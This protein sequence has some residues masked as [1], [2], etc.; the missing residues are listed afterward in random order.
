MTYPTFPSGRLGFEASRPPG[1]PSA[2]RRDGATSAGDIAVGVV[3]GRASEYFDF[4]VYGIAS[5]L[6][7]PAVFFPGHS[8]LDGLLASFAVFALAFLARPFGTVAGMAVQRRLGRRGKLIFALALL[9][10]A[11]CTMALLPGA[12]EI[13]SAAVVLLALCRVVQG[14]AL[15]A[16]WDG[17]PSLL[18][19][20]APADRRGW[21]A[22][23]GQLGAPLG[24]GLAALLYAFLWGRLGA[25]DLL[26]WGW[27]FPFFVAFAINV[28]ALFARLQLVLDEDTADALRRSELEPC[29]LSELR[30][31]AATLGIG[32]FA[33]LASFALVHLLTVFPLSW[34]SLQATREPDSVL[35]LQAAAAGL[36]VAAMP[37]SGWLADRI[38]RRTTLG[39]GA[40]AIGLFALA[41]PWLLDGGHAGQDLYFLLGFA[42]FGIS[43][44]QAAGAVAA[45]FP[46]RVRY[47]GAALSA[48]L[49]W[50]VGAGF[51]P[52]VALALSARFGLGA[53]SLYLLSGVAATL[54]ALKI[55]R[56]LRY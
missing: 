20:R 46:A 53:L 43:Y 6:V 29:N 40:A 37:V 13:G 33:A 19:I 49:A 2:P 47:L 42:L 12:D 9:G 23:L 15:G 56:A 5:A 52:L 14:F 41:A 55:N 3:V 35:W 38:G 51:A 16:S 44:G 39:A 50:L 26:S 1:A 21:Y 7:F 18:A 8:R 4:F 48:D 28:V 25:D 34:L 36:A 32:A 24:F 31:H 22:M 10:S 45:N 54:L 17:L 27:R 11:T 30:P